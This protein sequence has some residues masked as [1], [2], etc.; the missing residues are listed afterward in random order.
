MNIREYANG[1]AYT[2]NGLT[3]LFPFG[4]DP[5]YLFGRIPVRIS[6]PERFGYWDTPNNRRSFV[7]AFYDGS[8]I[9]AVE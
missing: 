7:R 1:I 9:T 4:G 3:V 8:V 6:N 5:K 2:L